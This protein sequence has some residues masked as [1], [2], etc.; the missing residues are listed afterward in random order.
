MYLYERKRVN[1]MKR[2]VKITTYWDRISAEKLCEESIRTGVA[3]ASLIRFHALR[4]LSHHSVDELAGNPNSRNVRFRP[5]V[6][7]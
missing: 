5:G 6:D 7:R 4:S 3:A 1:Q 2:D